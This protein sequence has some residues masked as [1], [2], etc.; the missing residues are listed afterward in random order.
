MK[1]ENEFKS[2]EK[3]TFDIR[4]KNYRE[5]VEEKIKKY[6]QREKHPR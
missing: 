1:I 2:R 3:K 4:K 5:K 6:R